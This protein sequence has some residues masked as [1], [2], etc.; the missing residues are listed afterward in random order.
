MKIIRAS[1]NRNEAKDSLIL[2]YNL[3]DRQ[4]SAILDLKLYQL[5]GMEREK[6]DAE[7]KEL[8]S[9][10]SGL[11][12]IIENEHILLSL[13]KDELIILRTVMVILVSVKLL[14][15]K[16]MFVWKTLFQTTD[17]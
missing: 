13:I 12:E 17:V 4:A 10:I 6:I 11:K 5:T 14:N 8:M 3:T 9:I 7:Y 1:S 2:K 16:E 15:M